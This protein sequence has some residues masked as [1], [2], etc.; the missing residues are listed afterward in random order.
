MS[1]PYETPSPLDKRQLRHSFARAA[2]GY[3]KVAVLQREVGQRILER[4]DVVRLQPH[5][6]L[7]VGAGTGVGSAS[8]AKRYRQA[9]VVAV[10]IAHPML[11]QARRRAPW[12]RKMG[13]V[14]ADAE[15]LPFARDCVDL[16][17][18]NLTLQWCP[19]LEGTL[20]GFER[21]LKPG[22]LLMFTTFG[23]DTLM[24]LRASWAKVDRY[25]HVMPFWDMHNIGDALI[26]AGFAQPVMDVEHFT[27]TY[28]DIQGL[29]R[30]LRGVGSHNITPGRAPGLTG[31][32]RL[33]ALAATYETYRQGG[34]LPATYEVV[35]GH[36]WAP[37]NRHQAHVGQ[38]VVEVP[39][40]D[41]RR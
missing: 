31:K 11:V 7:D 25:S 39:V 12:F 2:A 6:V 40:G 23:P 3:D 5:I 35:Y 26:R 27:L 28:R 4:L 36:C 20:Q 1:T 8:L 15:G 30:D 14:C 17:F 34:K 33:Q 32:R 21:I 37:A 41:L 16:L 24:E 38:P 18:S 13:Y 10:D 9:R 19:Q 22:A 29:L